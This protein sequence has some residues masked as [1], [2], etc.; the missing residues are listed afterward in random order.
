[1]DINPF[2]ISRN[3]EIRV[4]KKRSLNFSK[5]DFF[6]IIIFIKI[7]ST[8]SH[9]DPATKKI[10]KETFKFVGKI[11]VTGILYGLAAKIWRL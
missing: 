2:I 10:L 5:W 8:R 7:N 11:V 1:M 3:A 4:R 9:M 6:F